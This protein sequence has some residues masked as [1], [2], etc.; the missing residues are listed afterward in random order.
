MFLI[1]IFIVAFF[2]S[3]PTCPKIFFAKNKKKAKLKIIK[4]LIK[5]K[6]TKIKL[7]FK[8]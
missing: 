5:A 2:M 3:F 4:K 1:F 7:A 8:S 6:I